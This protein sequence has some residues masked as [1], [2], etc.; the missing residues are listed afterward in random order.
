MI[1]AAPQPLVLRDVHVPP[2]PGWWPP[3]PGWWLA[4][5]VIALAV[6]IPLLLQQRRRARRRRWAALF[7]RDCDAASAPPVQVAAASEL[8]RRAARNVDRHADRLQGQAWLTFLDGTNGQPFSAGPG[9][10]LEDGGYRR[11]VDPRQL[12][13][14]R[15]LARA[16]F[17]QLMEGRR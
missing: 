13:Q 11:R 8:L 16:R 3:A 5:L 17:V 14:L 12:E 9:R 1:A 6:A 4:L 15:E 10:L 7:D 2:A